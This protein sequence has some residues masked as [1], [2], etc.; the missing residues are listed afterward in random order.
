M[1]VL[2]AVTRQRKQEQE[3]VEVE[4]DASKIAVSDSHNLR[5]LIFYNK[6][7]QTII[8]HFFPI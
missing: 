7:A 4:N 5:S 8:S 6:G 3:A 1:M 2:D